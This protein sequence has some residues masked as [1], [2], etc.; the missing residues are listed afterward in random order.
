MA[1]VCRRRCASTEAADI[2]TLRLRVSLVVFRAE[3]CREK[4]FDVLGSGLEACAG[5]TAPKFVTGA[6]KSLSPGNETGNEISGLGKFYDFSPLDESYVKLT[7]GSGPKKT[8]RP[9]GNK[10]Q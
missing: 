3:L 5:G 4:A 7:I 9:S 6:D 1:L 8:H 2:D 10:L